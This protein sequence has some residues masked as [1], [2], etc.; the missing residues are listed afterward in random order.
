MA[1][2]TT[3]HSIERE[4]RVKLRVIESVAEFREACHAV[5]R[6]GE[7]LGL[8]PT[9]GALHEGHL[10]LVEDARRRSDVVAVTIFVNPT[11]F[12]PH[13]DFARYPRNLEA[14]VERCRA[15]GASLVFAPPTTEMYPPGERTRVRVS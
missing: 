10:A 9:M 15:A 14:D 5:R 2:R 7:R 1:P 11:Q 6:G 8:V 3:S 12:G 4:R 13:E